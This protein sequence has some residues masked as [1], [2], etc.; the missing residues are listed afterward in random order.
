M[1]R[2][3]SKINDIKKAINSIEDYLKSTKFYELDDI[4]RFG[5]L[6]LLQVIGEA[7]NLVSDDLKSR[8]K[9]IK[10]K[11]IIGF[12]NFVVHQ[13]MNIKWEIVEHVLNVD[14]SVLKK[15]IYSIEL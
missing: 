2:D 10:W 12:R 9:D 6:Y 15:Q 1:N 3:L 4:Q 13:Y 7:A 14:L 11:E 5:I 8:H